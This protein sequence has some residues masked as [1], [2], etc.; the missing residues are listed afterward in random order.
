M[1]SS[2]AGYDY[3]TTTYSV[4]GRI[5]QV[6]YAQKAVEN[7]GTAIG[8][9]CADGVVVAC[10]SVKP[11]AMVVASSVRLTQN[12]DKRVVCA[13]TGWAPDGRQLVARAREEA[14]HYEE[15]YAVA[16]P[17]AVLASR[18]A[19]Y[20]HFFTLHGSLRPFGATMLL[21]GYDEEKETHE[22]YMIEPNGDSFRYF[23]CATG[24]G[25]QAAKTEVEKL[26]LNNMTCREAIK[27]IAKIHYK[28]FD[29]S[30]DK[31]FDLDMS[32]ICEENAWMAEAVPKD[33]I[34]EA[35]AWAKAKLEEED[36]MD[37]DDEDE[38]GEA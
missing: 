6:E 31:P 26:E 19:Q 14:H 21:A 18:V 16:A 37:D 17:P 10:E 29:E 23:G 28:L 35:V 22:L 32:W 7:S 36:D 38:E 30:K 27:E 24:K 13:T 5:F 2:G 8:V 9:R 34:D 1:S 4:D 20:T 15:S 11:G 3:S 25:R 33:V 12:V